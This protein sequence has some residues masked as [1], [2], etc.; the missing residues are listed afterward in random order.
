MQHNFE[1]YVLTDTLTPAIWTKFYQAVMQYS[2][3]LGKFELTVRL[4]DNVVRFFIRSDKD[5]SALSNNIDGLLLQP[6]SVAE[7]Q[8]PSSRSQERLVQFV[9]GGNLLDLKEKYAVK[10]AKDLE[11]VVLKVRGL[12]TQK[13]FGHINLYFKGV[14]GHYTIADKIL[15]SFPI[16]LLAINFKDNVRYLKKTVPL[17]LNIEK[18]LHMLTSSKTD[19]LFEIDTFPYFPQSYYLGLHNYE[20]DKHSLIIGA[21]GTG[22]SKLISLFVDRLHRTA[23]RMNYRVVI[24]DPHAALADDLAHIP[25]AKVVNFTSEGA[26]LFAESAADITAAT[27]LTATLFKSLLGDQFNARLD[28][29]LRFSLFVLL[30]AQS[31]SLD[32]LKRFLSDIELR[33]KVINHVTGYVPQ[34]VV[35]FF[36][37]DFNEIRT[38]QYNEAIL[39]IISLVDELQLQPAIG[40]GGDIS[41]ARTVQENF[42]TI[43]SLNKMSMGEKTTKTIAG[44]LIQQ[45]FLLAQARAFGQ[46][47]ILVIDEVSVI[48]NPTLSSILAEARKFN[49]SVIL[50]QQYFGQIEKDLQAAI[51]SNVYNYYVFKTSEE[52][53]RAL[54]GNLNI[55]LPKEI[56]AAEHDKGHKEADVRVR[57]MTELHPRECLI[58]LSG[59]GQLNP[60]LK[61]RTVDAPILQRSP[62]TTLAHYRE[63]H[64]PAK[65]SEM[66]TTQPNLEPYQ[67]ESSAEPASFRGLSL[68]EILAGQSSSRKKISKKKEQ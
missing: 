8:P 51:F 60:C 34:N 50:T 42:L 66:L 46:K 21:T 40:K 56:V 18:S 4:T 20:F 26:E 23:L 49:L 55:D 22:K 43:F 58:R 64:L 38:K 12:G 59:N 41:L 7:T 35:Q 53:A 65:F 62:K 3:L 5:L 61:A 36:G 11:F 39:P 28:R 15:T 9:A 44:L 45:I 33:T 2:G 37:S 52:D 54:E 17:Y 30:T 24:V 68:S 10:K 13:S 47:I 25:E 1:L 48:Q 63:Q 32:T 14:A 27:E 6:I 57:I 31:M 29:V 16:S 19:A 67:P